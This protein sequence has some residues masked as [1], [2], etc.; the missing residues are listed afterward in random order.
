MK[1]TVRYFSLAIAALAVGGF[2][3]TNSSEN[4]YSPRTQEDLN[5]N[6]EGI[7]GAFEYLH[8]LKA[9]QVTGEYSRQDIDLVREEIA[10]QRKLSKTTFPLVW[11][12]AGPDNIGGRTRAILID[13]ND[14]NI[15]YAGG[16]SG[17]VFKST[18]KGASWYPVEGVM[19]NLN[20]GSICQTSNGDIYVGTG[21]AFA[22]GPA[23]SELGTP[24]FPGDGIYKT[25][26]GGKTFEKLTTSSIFTYVNELAVR[27]NTNDIYAATNLGLYNST[28]EGTTW[29]RILPGNCRDFVFDKNGNILAYVG[30]LIYHSTTPGDG[31]SYVR[32]EGVSN[33]SRAAL[34][35]SHSD[36]N[37][38]Y[39]VVSGGVSFEGPN[40]L[41]SV[42]SGLIGIFQSK[43][44][45]KTFSRI[46]GQTSLF[47][48]PLTHVNLG[49]SQGT[50]NL[51]IAV[52]PKDPERV[53]LG[54][55]EFAEWTDDEGP[56][57]VGN[58]N[59]HPANPF[60]IHADKHVIKFDLESDPPIMYIGCDGG[61]YKTT[62]ATLDRY[63]PSNIG[64]Q[65]TQFYGISAGKNG[66]IAGGTQDNNSLVIDG[67]GSTPQ[68]GEI[69][70]GGDGFKCA[71]SQKNPDILF[72]QSQFG[73]L[74]RSLK[75]RVI[76]KPNF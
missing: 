8:S 4:A 51:C 20:I 5:Q 57:I 37:Y 40:G 62:N 28:N 13:N 27:P 38:A 73:N 33:G 21:E 66:I 39:V 42:N 54:G 70:L 47:F 74:V 23:G 19:D 72:A 29:T 17:G 35:Y 32:S 76:S 18:N 64:Y 2:Y 63:A 16:V 9:N 25:T 60:G 58:L 6:Q 14:N 52:D 15:L 12:N 56:K 55:I 61:I 22:T 1:K 67:K 7:H 68:A 44:N 31:N 48:S 75:C 45:G 34:A 24:G 69:I 46:V 59:G 49:R 36:P 43:D 65:T 53:F 26:D 30:P 41:V 10:G 11:E 71:V 3:I 50:Y